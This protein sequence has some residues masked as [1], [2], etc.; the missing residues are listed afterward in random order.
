MNTPTTQP[1]LNPGE[2]YA[3]VTTPHDASQP[4]HHLILLPARPD[5]R[6]GWD[7]AREWAASVGGDLPTPQEQAQLF[8]N[9]RDNLPKA[10]CW[11]NNEEDASYAWGCTFG[12]GHQYDTHKSFDG[13]AVAVRRLTLE[14]FNSLVL[15][16]G[17]A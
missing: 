4:S 12:N 5:K 7:A 15:Q 9:C 6:M 1:A 11:S 14:S 16:G 3:G 8:A 13:S 17:A 2:H 10:W